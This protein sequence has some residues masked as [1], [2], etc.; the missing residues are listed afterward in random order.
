MTEYG[1]PTQ[2]LHRHTLSHSFFLSSLMK[3]YTQSFRLWSILVAASPTKA[4]Y[5]H[6]A[7]SLAFILEGHIYQSLHLYSSF[8]KNLT[9][10]EIPSFVSHLIRFYN[11]PEISHCQVTFSTNNLTKQFRYRQSQPNLPIYNSNFFDVLSSDIDSDFNLM[12]IDT[13]SSQSPSSSPKQQVIALWT[14]DAGVSELSD[15]IFSSLQQKKNN[16]KKILVKLKRILPITRNHNII[17][18]VPPPLINTYASTSFVIEVFLLRSPLS[19][20]S[21]PL[22][23]Q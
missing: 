1:T 7:L 3:Q 10:G 17:L 2:S 20:Y 16:A 6:E 15:D 11:Q 8:D 18:L 19:N 12:D 23:Q 22:L 9:Q 21:S 14:T 5:L 4:D 13:S